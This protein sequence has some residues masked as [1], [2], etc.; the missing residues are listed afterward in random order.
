[1]AKFTPGHS[2]NTA[3]R[4][5]GGKDRRTQLRELFKPHA[6]ALIAKA[7]SMALAGDTTALR[8]CLDRIVPA[9]KPQTEPV[10]LDL[11]T[12]T[13]TDQAASIFEAVTSG[14]ISTDDA[15]ALIGI[16]ADQA[17]LRDEDENHTNIKSIKALLEAL[18]P[19]SVTT[20]GYYPRR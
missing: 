6:E 8:L 5:K 17:R 1:M 12:G 11:P 9:L 19:K 18:Q 13:L 10:T 14:K 7:V 2:G 16:L 3:G 20:R 15:A 4:P